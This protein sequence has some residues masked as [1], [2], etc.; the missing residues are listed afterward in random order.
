M[1]PL[2]FLHKISIS[3][4]GPELK[5]CPIQTADTFRRGNRVPALLTLKTRVGLR[6]CDHQRSPTVRTHTRPRCRTG[7]ESGSRKRGQQR[8]GR[9]SQELSPRARG[10]CVVC[11][12]PQTQERRP[13]RVL[14]SERGL[15]AWRRPRWQ[16]L[17]VLRDGGQESH[18][19]SARGTSPRGIFNGRTELAG[20]RWG[21]HLTRTNLRPGNPSG[22]RGRPALPVSAML[23]FNLRHRKRLFLGQNF[24]KL[25]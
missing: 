5:M 23:L 1:Q 19:I 7:S 25:K 17:H 20:G 6:E 3:I 13:G 18:V 21:A 11:M 14:E 2:S 24:Y 4:V 9:K 22:R 15:S 8:E 16:R 10:H 12:Q